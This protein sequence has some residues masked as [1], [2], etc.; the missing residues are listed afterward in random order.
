MAALDA[1]AGPAWEA[2]VRDHLRHRA[3]TGEF[4]DLVAV[5]RWWRDAP[6]PVEIDAVA[7][8]GP[9]RSPVVVAEVKWT[10]TVDAR[11]IRRDLD[12]AVALLPGGASAKVAIAA[13]EQVRDADDELVIT[14]ADVFRG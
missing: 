11:R 10:R 8:A 1:H 9:A 2:A 5:G 7:L 3:A 13:R 14:A 6:Q 12:H 4:G